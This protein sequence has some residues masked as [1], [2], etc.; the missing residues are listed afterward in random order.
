[1]RLFRPCLLAAVL[2]A[3]GPPRADAQCVLEGVTHLASLRDAGASPLPIIQAMR[4]TLSGP[5]ATVEGL[6]PL[7]FR[8]LLAAES[9]DLFVG[10]TGFASGLLS[11]S[12][13]VRVRVLG[14]SGTD[15]IAALGD[16][17]DLVVRELRLPCSALRTTPGPVGTSASPPRFASN[18]RWVSQSFVQRGMRCTRNRGGSV[19][20]IDT[21]LPGRCQPVGDASDCGY[22]PLRGG[23]RLQLRPDSNS[24]S[25]VVK[26]SRDVT[27]V[28]EDGRPG[29]LRVVSR[30]LS[31]NRLVVGGWVRQSEVRWAQEVP[32][33]L[34]N[35]GLGTVSM[36]PGRSRQRDTRVGFVTLAPDTPIL[37]ATGREL[38]RVFETP[39]CSAAEQLPNAAHVLIA[40]PGSGLATNPAR[41]AAD[42]VRWVPSCAP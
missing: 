5:R 10:S 27:F 18:P 21:V 33:S 38:G 30:G 13:G 22:H 17:D 39:H 34:R 31:G 24:P 32:P 23:L 37:D 2:V 16:T 36:L 28:D 15:V 1:M 14:T 20:C 4:I 3:L 8:T 35:L 19:A 41:A 25:I 40:L 11:A 42:Q 7:A 29:W 9:V 26:A 12:P 6:R